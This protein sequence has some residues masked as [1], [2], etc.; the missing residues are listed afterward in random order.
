[1]Y[2]FWLV[3][4]FFYGKAYIDTARINIIIISQ[5][6]LKFQLFHV[7]IGWV[8][9]FF[10]SVYVLEHPLKFKFKKT[11]YIFSDFLIIFSRTDQLPN[12]LYFF[13]CIV[14]IRGCSI[15]SRRTTSIILRRNSVSYKNF[16][17]YFSLHRYLNTLKYSFFFFV[18][19]FFLF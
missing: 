19:F 18:R 1:M 10:P 5:Q 9:N 16:I 13:F 2:K 4:F 14:I 12:F 17:A 7:S 6:N 8:G 11:R 15:Y 3:F